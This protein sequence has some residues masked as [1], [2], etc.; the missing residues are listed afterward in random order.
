MHC[1]WRTER[2]MFSP[3]RTIKKR[4]MVCPHCRQWSKRGVCQ[5]CGFNALDENA[6]IQ[7]RAEEARMRAE[8]Q[9]RRKLTASGLFRV[10]ADEQ[11][12]TLKMFIKWTTLSSLAGVLA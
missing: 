8:L 1:N 2:A 12:A 10:N 3:I 5:H 7:L 6:I 4:Y 11:W 9:S